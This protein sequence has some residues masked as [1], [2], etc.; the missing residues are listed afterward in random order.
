MI[1]STSRPVVAALCHVVGSTNRMYIAAVLGG[2]F[3]DGLY[4]YL[5]VPSSHPKL[6]ELLPTVNV[7][8]V[9]K[10][11]NPFLT[12]GWSRSDW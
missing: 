4:Q 1:C 7:R 12:V 6:D 11:N 9:D 2:A 5:A 3:A 10:D 8:F